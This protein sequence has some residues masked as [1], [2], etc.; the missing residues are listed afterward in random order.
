MYITFIKGLKQCFC[1]GLAPSKIFNLVS[2]SKCNFKFELTTYE[3][4]T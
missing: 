4:I 3:T 2:M 1:D